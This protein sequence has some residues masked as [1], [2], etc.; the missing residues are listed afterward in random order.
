ME[1][2]ASAVLGVEPELQPAAASEVTTNAVKAG[3]RTRCLC[4]ALSFRREG[5]YQE[6]ATDRTARGG[7]AVSARTVIQR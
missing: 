1:V 4:M 7:P 3:K 6:R 2:P 5:S